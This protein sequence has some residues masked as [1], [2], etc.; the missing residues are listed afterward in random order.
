VHDAGTAL[1][2]GSR[3]YARRQQAAEHGIELDQHSLDILERFAR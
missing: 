1:L 3:R 2:P